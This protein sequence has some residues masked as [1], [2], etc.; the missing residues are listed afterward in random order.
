M[1]NQLINFDTF[2]IPFGY[3]CQDLFF[4]LPQC[5]NAAIQTQA[6]KHR[7]LSPDHVQPT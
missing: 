5:W 2:R 4:K 7:K 3:Q 1:E 6:E